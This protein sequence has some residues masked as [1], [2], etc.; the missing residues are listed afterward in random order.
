MTNMERIN[1]FLAE[2]SLKHVMTE[3]TVG[4]EQDYYKAN[5]KIKEIKAKGDKMTDSDRK[6]LED[7][8]KKKAEISK[9]VREYA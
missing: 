5:D 8:E 6:E 9:K 3:L 7:H 2:N 1:K 4:F